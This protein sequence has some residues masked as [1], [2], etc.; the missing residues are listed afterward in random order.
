MFLSRTPDQNIVSSNFG[1]NQTMQWFFFPS[2]L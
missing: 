2:F 1:D